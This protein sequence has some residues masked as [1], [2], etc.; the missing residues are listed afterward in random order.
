LYTD[1]EATGTK[2]T[3]YVPYILLFVALLIALGFEFVK[4]LAPAARPCGLRG[5]TAQS[6][7]LATQNSRTR[8]GTLRAAA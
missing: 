5:L 4:P 7:L 8:S 2:V 1:V 3:S 6:V